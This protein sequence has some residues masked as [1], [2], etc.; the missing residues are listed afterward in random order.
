MSCF[1][2]DPR[3]DNGSENNKRYIEMLLGDYPDI[4]KSKYCEQCLKEH[5]EIVEP[6][7]CVY[8]IELQKTFP[9]QDHIFLDDDELPEQKNNS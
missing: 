1:I 4:K 3:L 5:Q 6:I 9:N 8:M 2:D 7:G